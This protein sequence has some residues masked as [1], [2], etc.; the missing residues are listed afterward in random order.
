MRR[1]KE[2]KLP[3]AKSLVY[4]PFLGW[5]TKLVKK[6][7][8]YYVVIDKRVLRTTLIAPGTHIYSYFGYDDAG[9]PI[10][11]TFLD[12]KNLRGEIENL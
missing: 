1:P 8:S 7:C 10:M 2:I 4:A 9:R 11:V 6:R 3:N 5:K 12:A